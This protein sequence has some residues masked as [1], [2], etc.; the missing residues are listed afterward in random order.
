MKYLVP[1]LIVAVVAGS[2][3]VY[4][5]ESNKRRESI[6]SAATLLAGC[7]RKLDRATNDIFAQQADEKK[8]ELAALTRQMDGVQEEIYQFYESTGGDYRAQNETSKALFEQ[9]EQLYQQIDQLA[10]TPRKRLDNAMLELAANYV[11]QQ[12]AGETDPNVLKTAEL[13]KTAQSVIFNEIAQLDQ[14]VE[15][16]FDANASLTKLLDEA[17]Y[18][19]RQQQVMAARDSLQSL[20]DNGFGMVE[21]TRQALVESGLDED[22]RVA[23]WDVIRQFKTPDIGKSLFEKRVIEHADTIIAIN[24][25][26]YDNRKDMRAGDDDLLLINN[27]KVKHQLD[28][29]V[30]QLSN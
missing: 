18:T 29:Y 26:I 30:Q 19:Q 20:R 28:R 16:L 4:I 2:L 14:A 17:Y 21:K 24:Q 12:I 25:L 22:Y 23:L 1:F 8:Q 15:Q 27:P 11:D 9:R 7:T 13:C 3:Y 6:A 5:T 10:H